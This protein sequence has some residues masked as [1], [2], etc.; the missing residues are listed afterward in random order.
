MTPAEIET[1]LSE[2]RIA[3]LVTLREDGSPHV[4]PVWYQYR[5]GTFHVISYAFAVKLL[6]IQRDPRVAVSIPK[7]DR[8][9]EH[10]VLEGTATV[11]Q[12]DV[13]QTIMDISV[14]YLG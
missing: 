7:P 5:A 13:T 10:V 12:E 8:P 1:Y 14:R 3:D 11:T 4:S 6:N 2:A 9:Y